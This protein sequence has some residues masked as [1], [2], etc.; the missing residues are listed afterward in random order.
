M[1][2][3]RSLLLITVDCFRADHAGFLGYRRPTTPFLDSL[4]KESVALSN[5]IVAG[6]P[7]YF[8]FPGI[9]ASRYPLALG[10]D[11]VGLAPGEPTIASTLNEVGYATA[12]FLAANPYLSP[13]FGYNSGFCVFEDFLDG[14]VGST[15]PDSDGS[16]RTGMPS[17]WNQR[18]AKAS[19]AFGPVG[20]L[21]D[22]LY[23]QY[24]QRLA[25][26]EKLT[27]GQLRRFPAAD[28]M[29]DRARDWLTE[30]AGQ[31][32][33][34][35]LHLMDPHSPYY[36]NQEAFELMEQNSLDGSRVRYLNSFWNRGDLGTARLKR[37]REEV[38]ALYDA[39]IRWVDTQV[40]RLV[41][42]LRALQMWQ[43]CVLALTADHGEQFLD[44]GGRYHQPSN[45]SEEVVRVPLLLRWPGLTQS[46]VLPAPFS[47]L[48]L[49]PSLL[50]LVGAPIPGS[51]RGRSHADL[52]GAGRGWDG[53]A[54]VECIG[55]CNNPFV[56]ENRLRARVLAIRE[57]RYK[58]VF[59][60]TSAG[61]Q[62]YDLDADPGE[63][64]PLPRDV[65]IS[66]RKRL[67][68]HL[69][70]HISD[71]LRSR[72]TDHRLAARLRDLRLECPS[73]AVRLT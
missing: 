38:I 68:D 19:H 12:A 25:S 48:H 67:L 73:P 24:C 32:F 47:L 49:A 34:L 36:P 44:H 64:R 21:Y 46:A 35:W 31:P 66:V 4:A 70:K 8:S 23:F 26:S 9:M 57:K 30:I 15:P 50:D 43:N 69:Q 53:T 54:I 11:V 45:V 1:K 37:H 72:D 60:F 33:F 29:V 16:E 13:R 3:T 10:R 6:A 63:Q 51:F 28:V 27:L 56:Q 22:E 62:L 17:R 65:E 40:S 5:A 20:S 71:S 14:E 59:D 2:S 52:L 42:T 18:L 61:E 39:G 55:G 41:D 7:T 58:L